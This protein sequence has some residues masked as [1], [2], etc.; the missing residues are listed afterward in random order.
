[1]YNKSDRLWKKGIAAALALTI[2]CGAAPFS[3]LGSNTALNGITAEAAETSSASKKS[4]IE[5]VFTFKQDYDNYWVNAFIPVSD[6]EGLKVT[7]NGKAV[8]IYYSE[9]G[10]NA[11]IKTEPKKMGDEFTLTVKKDKKV[12]SEKKTTIKDIAMNIINADENAP[13]A[14]AFKWMLHYGAA[15][16][17]YFNYKTDSLVDAE[18]TNTPIQG[19]PSLNSCKFDNKAMNEYLKSIDAPVVYDGMSIILDADIG[20]KILFSPAENVDFKT[21]EEYFYKKIKFADSDYIKEVNGNKFC[22]VKKNISLYD[23]YTNY[24]LQIGKA[25]R[26]V[27]LM[28][29]IANAYTEKKDTE[30]HKKLKELLRALMMYRNFTSNV[31]LID[32]NIEIEYPKSEE[33]PAVTTSTSSPVITTTLTST[34]GNSM[35]TSTTSKSDDKT[36]E[37]IT[38]TVTAET[39]DAINF[40]PTKDKGIYISDY[41]FDKD[42]NISAY[43]FND[44]DKILLVRHNPTYTLGKIVDTHTFEIL[45]EINLS[46]EYTLF[47]ENNYIQI[48][49]RNTE[50]TEFYDPSFNLVQSFKQEEGSYIVAH[51]NDLNYFGIENYKNGEKYI[52]DLKNDTRISL[53]EELA[54]GYIRGFCDDH[55]IIGTNEDMYAYYLDGS[56]EI[57]YNSPETYMPDYYKYD[58]I[59]N[60]NNMTIQ[61]TTTGE[62]ICVVHDTDKDEYLTAYLGD[63]FITNSKRKYIT[64]YDRVNNKK[65]QKYTLSDFYLMNVTDNN[66]VFGVAIM[67]NIM[68]YVKIDLSEIDYNIDCTIDIPENKEPGFETYFKKPETSD[69]ELR[70]L[71]DELDEKYNVAVSFELADDLDHSIDYYDTDDFTGDKVAILNDIKDY[72]S[73]WPEDICRE[74]TGDPD[75]KVWI[76]ICDSITP[77]VNDPEIIEPAAY[78]TKYFDTPTMVTTGFDNNTDRFLNTFSHEFIHLLDYQL[79]YDQIMEWE[80]LSPEDAYMYSY[81]NYFGLDKYVDYYSGDTDIYFSRDYGR[82]NPEEDRATIGE[83]L[84]DS[85]VQEA[86]AKSLDFDG[87]KAKCEALCRFIRENYPCLASVP[88]GELYLEKA[89]N[90]QAEDFVPMNYEDYD[91]SYGFGQG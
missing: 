63:H 67:N 35:V 66:T 16:Q 61:S 81:A 74:I 47:S 38:T 77:N 87:T 56:Y 52:Y 86:R 28:M 76:Y 25:S 57:T 14:K 59:K 43:H 40:V 21:A 1:M 11:L 55:F 19:I 7:I 6:T 54:N 17:N 84:F 78:V 85:Y 31:N 23:V 39:K 3:Q 68:Y 50:T 72:L 24:S 8:P 46:K 80:T 45:K 36:P 49:N 26:N 53:P 62:N 34:S 73:L 64:F 33:V 65:S 10:I 29:Y 90:M 89:M 44:P 42:E 20:L 30:E 4:Y 5:P 75:M 27:S 9:D 70:S 82:T 32:R 12:I 91:Y 15:A 18:V 13:E 58:I 69:P 2:I 22:I 48:Y 79:T 88:V 51:D 41:S 60:K 71:V 37:N 83:V